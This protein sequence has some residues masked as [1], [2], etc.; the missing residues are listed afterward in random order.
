M[1]RVQYTVPQHDAALAVA[2]GCTHNKL[3]HV[4]CADCFAQH[5]AEIGAGAR[6]DREFFESHK[7]LHDEVVKLREAEKRHADEAFAL[8]EAL[9]EARRIHVEQGEYIATVQAEL[10]EMG[11]FKS[12]RDKAQRRH[13]D[14]AEKL[15]HMKDLHGDT[16]IECATLKN[17]LLATE[18]TLRKKIVELG[19]ACTVVA[20]R[21]AALRGAYNEVQ[22]LKTDR[23]EWEAAA[24][25]VMGLA[26]DWCT[27]SVAL[28]RMPEDLRALVFR[29]ATKVM[30]ETRVD[31]GADRADARKYVADFLRLCRSRVKQV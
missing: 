2:A 8:A 13:G 4:A 11:Q 29:D 12:Q 27:A 6:P 15:K 16:L 10:A 24:R 5:L 25:A 17:K 21:E 30:L 20:Q 9:Q 23:D 31:G 14:I 26:E 22:K 19:A 28:R 3:E 7:V 18:D 1:A